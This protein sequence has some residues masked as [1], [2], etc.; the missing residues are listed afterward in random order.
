VLRGLDLRGVFL[1]QIAHDDDVLVTVQCV[2]VEVHFG[3]ERDHLALAR[4]DQRIDFGERSI[5]FPEG[6][7]KALQNRTGPGDAGFGN[8]DLARQVVGV[9]VLQAGFGIDEYLVDLL[10]G[11]RGDFLDVHA[12]FGRRH[13]AHLLRAAIHHD[14]D[15][16]FLVDIGALF[17][18]QAPHLLALRPGLVGLQLHPENSP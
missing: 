5:G 6:T 9:G 1:V 18:Q 16:E 12:A 10:R 2:V 15:V 13:H 11:M 3:V 7:I 17:D 14:A 8:A 4:Q